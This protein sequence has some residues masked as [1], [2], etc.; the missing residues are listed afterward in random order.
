MKTN[1]TDKIE[2]SYFVKH[3]TGLVGVTLS[4]PL[5]DLRFTG[6]WD[7]DRW[8]RNDQPIWTFYRQNANGSCDIWDM[9]KKDL[10]RPSKP[11]KRSFQAAVE[12]W[13]RRHPAH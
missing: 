13:F 4:T 8:H 11:T 12:A 10:P 1:T 6:C 7:E 2:I 9:D 3:E 5:G